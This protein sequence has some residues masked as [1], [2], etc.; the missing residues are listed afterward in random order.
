MEAEKSIEKD[1][2]TASNIGLD[3]KHIKL[4][5]IPGIQLNPES[6]NPH[7][8]RINDDLRK[9]SEN[10]L[11]ERIRESNGKLTMNLN[12]MSKLEKISFIT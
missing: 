3:V 6:I 1:R 11:R 9:S 12:I 4:V 8:A 2:D 5:T 10:Q 7:N